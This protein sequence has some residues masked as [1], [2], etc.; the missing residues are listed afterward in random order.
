MMVFFFFLLGRSS[1]DKGYQ[2]YQGKRQ[3]D[4]NQAV[5]TF[6]HRNSLKGLSGFCKRRLVPSCLNKKQVLL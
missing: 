6:E 5:P 2:S 3:D 4:G 1:G